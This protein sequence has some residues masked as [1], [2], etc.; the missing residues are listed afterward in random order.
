M[1][2]IL[3]F[4]CVFTASALGTASV[5]LQ[6]YP[7]YSDGSWQYHFYCGAPWIFLFFTVK[8]WH[9]SLI[10]RRMLDARQSSPVL[11]R[12]EYIVTN[13]PSK[14]SILERGC[15]LFII[16]ALAAILKTL[17]IENIS[18]WLGSLILTC[19]LF[20]IVLMT[21]RRS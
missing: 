20:R 11:S 3:F 8:G 16:F 2:R 14:P 6:Q 19:L 12:G 1:F 18:W 17:F 5:M 10:W 15:I 4:L 21:V 13:K 9:I 7:L